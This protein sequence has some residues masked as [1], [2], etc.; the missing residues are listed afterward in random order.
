[1]KVV[2][3]AGGLGTRLAEETDKIPKPMVQIGNLPILIHIMRIY[4]FYGFK[5]FVI[6]GGY[7]HEELIRYFTNYLDF[8]LKKKNKHQHIFFSTNK[9][10]KVNIVFTGTKTNTGGRI[11]KIKDLIKEESFF[12]TYGDGLANINIKT[13][14][15]FHNKN[16]NIVTMTAVKPPGR[17]G[18]VKINKTIVTKFQEKVDNKNV[19]INGGFFVFKNEI[20]KYIKKDNDSLEKDVLTKITKIKKLNAYKH[21]NFWQPMDTLRDKNELNEIWKKG[22]APWK[23]SEKK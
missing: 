18:V 22:K 11:L 6:C 12:M 19:W 9:S 4:S 15:N 20:F 16:K 1:M 8:K 2:L 17:F 10:W 3:L 7:K 5:D 21:N 13:L 23:R 14:L